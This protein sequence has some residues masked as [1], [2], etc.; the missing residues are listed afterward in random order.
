MK[1]ISSGMTIWHRRVFPFLLFGFLAL[2]TSFAAPA[3]IKSGDSMFVLFIPVMLAIF[4]YFMMRWLVFPL[5]DEVF[6]DGDTVLVRKDG[7]EA[8]FPVRHIINVD[9]SMMTNPERITLTL[10]EPCELG[11]EIVFMPTYRFHFFSRHPIAEELIAKA[12]GL[13]PT[14]GQ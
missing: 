14:M 1:K 7:T 2:W 12:N 3:I 8:R 4:G 6:L 13:E 5:A 9:S 11:R 10:R